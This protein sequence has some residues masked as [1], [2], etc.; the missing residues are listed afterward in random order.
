VK[1]VAEARRV[2]GWWAIDVVGV[3]GAHTQARRLEQVAPMA[4]D[5]VAI[6]TNAVPRGIEIEV[7]PILDE[8]LAPVVDSVR[9]TR[10]ALS[11]L[12]KRSNT[13]TKAASVKLR[14]SGL[15]L[16]DAGRLLGISHQRVG[17][18]SGS[19]SK[20]VASGRQ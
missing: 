16:R 18:L 14:A 7:R 19:R 15:S 9:E 3:L 1:Y 5:V 10:Q 13:E 2:G 6:L 8:R 4:R 12:D 17:Q 20:R 11:E